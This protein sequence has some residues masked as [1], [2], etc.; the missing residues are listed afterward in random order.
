M[1][2][3]EFEIYEPIEFNADNPT[4]MQKDINGTKATISSGNVELNTQVP[5]SRKRGRPRKAD[6]KVDEQNLKTNTDKPATSN[7]ENNRKAESHNGPITRSKARK[8]QDISFARYT[9]VIE[10]EEERKDVLGQL[11]LASLNKDPTTYEEA[12]NSAESE[13]WKQAIKDELNSTEENS[14][15]DL[16]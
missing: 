2:Q 9:K 11:L 13:L 7:Q 16:T 10:S 3:N 15:W 12:M 1:P 5:T 4:N 8:V 14:V 6:L